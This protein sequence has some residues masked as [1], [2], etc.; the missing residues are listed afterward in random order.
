MKDSPIVVS[1]N[2]NK[3][4]QRLRMSYRFLLMR[5][6]FRVS[7][8]CTG[9]LY[10]LVELLSSVVLICSLTLPLHGLLM[11]RQGLTGKDVF[12]RKIIVG[13]RGKPV[14]VSTFAVAWPAVANLA[15]LYPVVTGKIGLVGASMEEVATHRFGPE[16]GYLLGSRP[17]IISL[18]YIRRSSNIGHEGR[19]ATEWEYRFTKKPAADFFLMLRAF[20]AYFFGS[21]I[22]PSQGSIDLFGI[23][24]A[25]LTMVEAVALI[26]K[27]VATG[28]GN[29]TFYF[30]NPDCLNK[31]F[32]DSDYQEIL[33][34]AD[35]VF[36]DGIGL[37]IA[38]KL[39]GSPLKENVNGTDMLPYLCAMVAAKGYKLFLLGGRPGV[40]ENMADNITEKYGVTVA[41]THHG[42]FHHEKE[43]SA[44]LEVI[45]A[46]GADIVLVAFGA[47]L[48]EKW[49]A[50]NRSKLQ[51]KAAL[52]VGG[53]FDF[54]SG[55]TRRAPRWLREMG[56]EWLYRIL[57][58]PGR[59]WKRYVIGNPL[60]LLRVLLWKIGSRR[61]S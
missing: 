34:K 31:T 39:M 41:G 52:G 21:S 11:L 60:F 36:P 33:A 27:M 59:M 2:L 55:N 51:T 10:R 50:A 42:F 47:P 3:L 58:E 23:K 1:D 12:L 56:L 15:L 29:E 44:V 45:N 7:L 57:Q 28:H 4:E 17:G 37:T 61:N 32:C 22:Q 14:A 54:Y 46:S 13:R 6:V 5:T 8:R 43:N 24:F 26:E 49:I 9:L 35:N 16:S 38:C 20:P 30:V 48:Q 19:L 18:W 25:N 40:A 53:L